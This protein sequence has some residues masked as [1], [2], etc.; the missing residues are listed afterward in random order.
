MSEEENRSY[1]ELFYDDKKGCGLRAMLIMA[2][3]M[4]VFFKQFEVEL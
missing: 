1:E 2:E 4:K 3:R